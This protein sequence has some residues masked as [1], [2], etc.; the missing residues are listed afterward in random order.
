MFGLA[1]AKIAHE[2]A[3]EFVVCADLN[4]LFDDKAI[5]YTKGFCQ[6]FAYVNR[7]VRAESPHSRP[8]MQNPYRVPQ[9]EVFSLWP[10][11]HSCRGQR[12]TQQAGIVSALRETSVLWAIVID[13]VF[14]GEALWW[15]YS[16]AISARRWN[17]FI[18]KW[19]T[20]PVRKFK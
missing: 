1:P 7:S 15:A 3:F 6:L 4:Q 8:L 17:E 14:L 16:E 2:S 5:S 9:A 11:T 10:L 20:Y 12:I 18:D 19:Y 13:R